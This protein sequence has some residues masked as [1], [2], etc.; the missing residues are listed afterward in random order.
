M[1]MFSVRM[2]PMNREENAKKRVMFD[3]E[4]NPSIFDEQKRKERK[5]GKEKKETK[6]RRN[7]IQFNV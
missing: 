1:V 7:P 3:C 2:D 6:K 4:V 5:G